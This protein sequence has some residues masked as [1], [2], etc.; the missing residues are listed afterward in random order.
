MPAHTSAVKISKS[1]KTATMSGAT[2]MRK[3]PSTSYAKVVSVPAGA[4]VTVEDT[5]YMDSNAS[6]EKRRVEKIIISLQLRQSRSLQQCLSK[7]VHL[8]LDAWI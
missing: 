4:T 6:V 5:V 3:G 1:V 8:K 7:M 2:N